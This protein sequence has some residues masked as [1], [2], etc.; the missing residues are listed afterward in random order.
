MCYRPIVQW[1][2]GLPL[3]KNKIIEE[4]DHAHNSK[5]RF[6]LAYWVMG[7]HF[8]VFTIYS[9]PSQLVS[10]YPGVEMLHFVR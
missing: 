7:R 3:Y 10:Q 2:V 5:Y 1:N 9:L 4:L 8:S 6:Y